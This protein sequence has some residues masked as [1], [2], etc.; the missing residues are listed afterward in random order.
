MKCTLREWKIEDKFD[1]D[2]S[3]VQEF[4][5]QGNKINLSQFLDFAKDSLIFSHNVLLDMNYINYELNLCHLKQIPIERFRCTQQ[6]FKEIFNKIE[7][8]FNLNCL[9]LEQCCQYCGL[10]WEVDPY[11]YSK[12]DILALKR[13][14]SVF[15]GKRIRFDALQLF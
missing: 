9:S 11:F 2:Y 13:R 8:T 4:L 1:T 10:E 7:P 3:S 12:S 5:P 6:I 15:N 14:K